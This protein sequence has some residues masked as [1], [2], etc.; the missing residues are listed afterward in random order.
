VSRRACLALAL[1]LPLALSSAAQAA[2]AE[3]AAPAPLAEGGVDTQTTTSADGR[4]TAWVHT[5]PGPPARTE[6][7]WQAGPGQ[8]PQ[9]L[10]Q[11]RGHADL[12]RALL[13]FNNPVFAADGLS[14]LVMTQ[15][16]AT[17]NAIHRV[18]LATRHVQ[19][20]AAGNSVQ[21]V[22]LGRW[23]GHLVVLKHKYAPGGG[24]LDHYWLLT[25]GGREVQELGRSEEDAQAFL[26]KATAKRR[27]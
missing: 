15:A 26:A 17:S 22:P 8:P 6:L 25:P 27:P 11:E 1:W 7:W 18:D 10:L 24:A 14:V 23:A 9:R 3:H 4:Q 20:V 5:L 2:Q 12:K 19:F 21:V 16:W 13:G